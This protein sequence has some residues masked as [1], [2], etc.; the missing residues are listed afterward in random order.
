MVMTASMQVFE[1]A[2]R[3][4]SGV[5]QGPK[6]AETLLLPPRRV[7]TTNVEALGAGLLH[8]LASYM[9]DGVPFREFVREMRGVHVVLV[10]LAIYMLLGVALGVV[11]VHY[12]YCYYRKSHPQKHVNHQDHQNYPEKVVCLRILYARSRC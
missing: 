5:F 3:E 7:H 10:V 11:K 9:T 12:S 2:V 8:S 4:H 1:G 6:R